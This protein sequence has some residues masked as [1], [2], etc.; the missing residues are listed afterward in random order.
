MAV[1]KKIAYN[2]VKNETIKRP[3]ESMK[4]KRFI[5]SMDFKYRDLIMELNFMK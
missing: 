3:K 2:A 1:L 4:A 5:A